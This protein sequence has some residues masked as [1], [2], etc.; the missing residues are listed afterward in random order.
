VQRVIPPNIKLHP[1]W[2]G[3]EEGSKVGLFCILSGFYP[4]KLSVEWQVDGRAVTTSPVQQKLQS[5]EGEENTFSLSS[6]LELDQSQWTQG[7]KVTCKATLNA[8][9]G[10]PVSRTTSICSGGFQ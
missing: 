3:M 4:D 2:E 9:Q 6:Q 10:P 5:V 8:S 1:L 7:S